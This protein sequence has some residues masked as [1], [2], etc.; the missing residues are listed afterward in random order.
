MKFL[1]FMVVLVLGAFIFYK[2]GINYTH[3][4]AKGGV[5]IVAKRDC[6]NEVIKILQTYSGEHGY[7]INGYKLNASKNVLS[8]SLKDGNGRDLMAIV[9]VEDGKYE[10]GF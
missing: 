8:Y 5:S 6:R 3:V 1:S 10:L 9:S 4:S 2:Y 7:S